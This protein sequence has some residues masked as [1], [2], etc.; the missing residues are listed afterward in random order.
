LKL[1]LQDKM[2][3]AHSSNP[4]SKKY[5]V[6]FFSDVPKETYSELL[7]AVEGLSDISN[8]LTFINGVN[9]TISDF[10]QLAE[11]ARINEVQWIEADGFEPIYDLDEA[12]VSANTITAHDPKPV[13]F[14][15]N[16][17]LQRLGVIEGCMPYDHVSFLPRLYNRLANTNCTVPDNHAV[18]SI[19][20]MAGDGSASPGD[21]S[22]GSSPNALIFA[23]SHNSSVSL[24]LLD[25]FYQ[26][27]LAPTVFDMTAMNNSWGITIQSMLDADVTSTAYDSFS[28]MF[29][30]LTSGVDETNTS[31]GTQRLNIVASAGNENYEMI[32]V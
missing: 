13:G 24:G 4:E 3:E 2:G 5:I 25:G 9:L 14:G 21:L 18:R 28:N 6:H 12:N 26:D 27:G 32:M 7:N 8:P 20:M 17:G 29:D 10:G 23:Y 16:G 31:T 1:G 19:G 30:E 22:K 11:L 15:L